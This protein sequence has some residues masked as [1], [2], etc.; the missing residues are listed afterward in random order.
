[1]TSL[2]VIFFNWEIPI[3]NGDSRLLTQILMGTL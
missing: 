1:M 3:S 2:E